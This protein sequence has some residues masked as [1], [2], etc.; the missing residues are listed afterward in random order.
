MS[1]DIEIGDTSNQESFSSHIPQRSF[2]VKFPDEKDLIRSEPQD[3][4]QPEPNNEVTNKRVFQRTAAGTF[5]PTRLHPSRR[6]KSILYA[7][8][9]WV[10]DNL[11]LN[12]FFRWTFR[13]SFGLL[14]VTA[15]L[16][17]FTWTAIFALLHAWNVT[18][19]PHCVSPVYEPGKN[20]ET[21]ADLFR[22]CWQLSWTTFAT[23]GYGAI[24]PSMVGSPF[25]S[26]NVNATEA[27]RV[28]KMDYYCFAQSFLCS[29]EA[30]TGILF[31]GFWT[32]VLFSKVAKV[33]NKARVIFSGP[34]T[35]RFGL[36]LSELKQDTRTYPCPVLEFRIV[37]KQHSQKGGG[38]IKASV[39]VV[40][41][42]RKE[43]LKEHVKQ[44][45]SIRNVAS[46]LFP[47]NRKKS[48]MSTLLH[49]KSV[50]EPE[51]SS[52]ILDQ[53]HEIH[54][55]QSSP[56][57]SVKS[58]GH[59]YVQDFN[60][61][62]SPQS[63]QSQYFMESSHPRTAGAFIFTPL[64]VEPG[65]FPLFT[66]VITIRHRLDDKSP[67]LQPKTRSVIKRFHG[68][69]PEDLCSN[70]EAVK[71]CIRFEKILVSFSGI[72]QLNASSVY[73]QKVYT[74]DDLLVG[75][76]FENLMVM[77]PFGCFVMDE[78]KVSN[79][80]EQWRH[81]YRTSAYRKEEKIHDE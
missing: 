58:I 71:K 9:A 15:Q 25:F 5:R 8:N 51:R 63:P 28:F 78:K 2:K 66:N 36:A 70:P 76:E 27:V 30:L 45:S 29:I 56:E 64:L 65:T 38:I 3:S 75:V 11:R 12:Q 31:A 13:S 74:R 67:L 33:N 46:I 6:H 18:E 10:I 44:K 53:S 32:A 57:L 21:F 4:A 61:P 62:P 39:N 42:L 19:Q 55:T 43:Q 59:S 7:P 34:M 69:W 52:S 40:A 1:S 17:F 77:K 35:V 14:L 48:I 47:M 81:K 26:D 72:S 22:D 60:S 41:S 73:A 23:V 50:L 79:T 80:Q 54:R 68:S 37:N 16:T 20:G 24:S 49:H